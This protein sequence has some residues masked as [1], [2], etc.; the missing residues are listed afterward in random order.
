MKT[1]SPTNHGADGPT[2]LT[3]RPPGAPGPTGMSTGSSWPRTAGCAPAAACRKQTVCA[4]C[5]SGKQAKEG[6]V[7]SPT[8]ACMRRT[9]VL[10][11]PHTARCTFAATDCCLHAHAHESGRRSNMPAAHMREKARSGKTCVGRYRSISRCV[12]R[13]CAQA[14]W[15]KGCAAAAG[16]GLAGQAAP[17]HWA[18]LQYCL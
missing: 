7:W 14:A 15:R 13:M 10:E 11:P 1:L 9:Y 12:N 18:S 2:A 5:E 3:G 4:A 8:A 16:R 6:K 17:C